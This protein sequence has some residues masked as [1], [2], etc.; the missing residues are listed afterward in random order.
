[1]SA[2]PDI[3]QLRL[4]PDEEIIEVLTTRREDQ[5]LERKSVR[6]TARQLGDALV[7]FANAE[8][9][10]VVIGIHSGRVEGVASAGSRIN[11]WRQAAVDYTEPPVRHKFELLPCTNSEGGVDEVAVIEIESSERVHTNVRGE[12]YLR[13]GDEN[14]RLGVV[15]AQELRFDKG[16][17]T[18]DGTAATSSSLSDLD[19]ERVDRYLRRIR[20]TS[21]EA[22]LGARGLVVERRRVT[23]PTVAGLLTFAPTPQSEFPEA[24]V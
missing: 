7:G 1:M 18:F 9:G 10:L 23:R 17:S 15:E 14:R 8:G 20:A 4:L 16:E 3:E 6:T 24:F 19:P 11:D 5:W 12:T 21:R 13:I 2:A 22:A